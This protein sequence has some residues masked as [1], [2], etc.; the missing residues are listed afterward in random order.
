MNKEEQRR[1]ER[2]EP[3]LFKQLFKK[4]I[5]EKCVKD[6]E[7]WVDQIMKDRVDPE[8]FITDPPG[9]HSQGAVIETSREIISDK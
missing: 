4:E 5:E 1:K 2:N 8:E 9:E 3:V 7:Q 6:M